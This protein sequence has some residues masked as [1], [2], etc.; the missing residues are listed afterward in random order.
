MSSVVDPTEY[1]RIPY[2]VYQTLHEKLQALSSGEVLLIKKFERNEGADVLIRLV[3]K[4]F[5]VTQISYDL[6][7]T[8]DDPRH[9]ITYNIGI[10]DLSLLTV[11]RFTEELVNHQN[12]YAINDVVMYVTESGIKDSAIVEEVYVHN[13]DPTRYAYKLS[14]DDEGLYAEDGLTPVL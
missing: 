2:T 8:E 1:T 4:K 11:F 7:E 6:Q 5:T 3:E 14:R 12:K 9:W 10:N 13:T